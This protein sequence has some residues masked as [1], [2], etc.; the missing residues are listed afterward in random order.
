M[1]EH[2]HGRIVAV[3]ETELIRVLGEDWPK[4]LGVPIMEVPADTLLLLHDPVGDALVERLLAEQTAV[5]R[6][7]ETG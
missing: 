7:T 4:R 6:E 1:N 3:A 5:D 2:E